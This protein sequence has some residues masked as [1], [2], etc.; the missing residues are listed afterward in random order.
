VGDVRGI[1]EVSVAQPIAVNIWS[2]KYLMVYFVLVATTGLTFITIQRQQAA[3]I[4]GIN[5]E[6]EA[7]NSFLSTLPSRISRYLPP[8]VY[9]SIFSGERDVAIQTERKSDHRVDVDVHRRPPGNQRRGRS[10]VPSEDEEE[11]RK[12]QSRLSGISA[13]I[14]PMF[15]ACN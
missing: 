8:Q 4:N 15:V 1:Q 12:A 7:T 10:I 13:L 3:L 14:F 6:L 2:F 11:C 9:K 5:Q